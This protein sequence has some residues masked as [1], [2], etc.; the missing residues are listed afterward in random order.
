MALCLSLHV[1]RDVDV[2]LVRMPLCRDVAPSV[3][4]NDSAAV[5][6][7]VRLH[8]HLMCEDIGAP[9]GAQVQYAMNDYQ[10]AGW[11]LGHWENHA[12]RAIERVLRKLLQLPKRPAVIMLG[13]FPH[14]IHEL[15]CGEG[16][17]DK[18]E[19]C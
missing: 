6:R 7:A 13:S 15:G 14:V 5:S 9:F 10:D 3:A 16:T 4:K 12:R 2:V 11:S 19:D 8:Q 17:P 1:D 18:Q